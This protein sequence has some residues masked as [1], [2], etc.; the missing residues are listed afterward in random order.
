M[1]FIVFRPAENNKA[2]KHRLESN[3]AFPTFAQIALQQTAV[4]THAHHP[5]LAPADPV[6]K[7]HATLAS[8]HSVPGHHARQRSCPI[9]WLPHV[10][11]PQTSRWFPV[12]NSASIHEQIHLARQ[13]RQRRHCHASGI[14]FQHQ[15]RNKNRV[16]QIRKWIVESLTRVRAAQRIE[17]G[18]SVLT[19]KHDY[20]VVGAK[21]CSAFLTSPNV[22]WSAALPLLRSRESASLRIARASFLSSANTAIRDKL[23]RTTPLAFS[24]RVSLSS[25]NSSR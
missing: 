21:A 10:P 11:S 9:R 23:M 24:E 14:I 25:A 13:S 3:R 15:L 18:V 6:R 4:T 1:P 16:S 17:V 5:T 8:A 2:S 12:L 7:R 20:R 22:Y 19:Y